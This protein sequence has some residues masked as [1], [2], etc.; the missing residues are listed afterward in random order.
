[1]DTRNERKRPYIVYRMWRPA[2]N[3]NQGIVKRAAAA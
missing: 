1:M 2:Q 3:P